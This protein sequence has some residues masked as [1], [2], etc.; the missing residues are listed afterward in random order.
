MTTV[1]IDFWSLIEQMRP[2]EI[3]D[4]LHGVF[5]P[6]RVMVTLKVG[7]ILYLPSVSFEV[8]LSVTHWDKVIIY[9]VQK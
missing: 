5:W 3:K 4:V 7:D 9:G 6:H 1:N 2:E 8:S